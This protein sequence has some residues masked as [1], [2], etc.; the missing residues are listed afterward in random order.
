MDDIARAGKAIGDPIRL[1][2][3]SLLAS[4]RDQVTCCV[5]PSD[6]CDGLCVCD[7]QEALGMG[8]SKVSYHIREL[9]AAGLVTE[10]QKGKWTYYA[11]NPAGFEAF[12][13]SLKSSF[14]SQSQQPNVAWVE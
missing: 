4:G 13:E 10:T 9:K 7:L 14:L 5:S 8:Q 1:Q 3:L 12:M 2:I 11:I 6:C